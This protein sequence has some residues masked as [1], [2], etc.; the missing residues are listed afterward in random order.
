MNEGA[1][2]QSQ[3]DKVAAMHSRPPPSPPGGECLGVEGQPHVDMCL[4]CVLCLQL[5][6]QNAVEDL[7]VSLFKTAEE[8][9]ESGEYVCTFGPSYSPLFVFCVHCS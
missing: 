5:V 9:A 2:M 3:A 8:A 1:A 7:A 6:N 4:E